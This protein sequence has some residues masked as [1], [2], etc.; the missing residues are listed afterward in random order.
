MKFDRSAP[1]RSVWRRI[2]TAAVTL[3]MSV[4][5]L[6]T[7]P[8]MPAQAVTNDL[9]I[10]V[11]SARTE[12]RAFGGA[13]VTKGDAIPDFKYIINVDNTGTT[14][15]RSPG[16]GCAADDPEYPASCNWPSIRRCP[17]RA[18]STPKVTRA[19]SP[20]ATP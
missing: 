14:E 15:Q 13:G 1:T 3:S 6:V 11:T 2:V 8:A 7:L 4:G 9:T 20:A 16:S 12:P 17:R 18:R 5:A 10:E 19:T